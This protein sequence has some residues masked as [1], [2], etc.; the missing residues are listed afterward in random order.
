LYPDHKIF[1]Q[2]ALSQLID[3]PEDHPERQSIR[4]R[5]SQ[6]VADFVLCRSDLSVVAVIE[7]DDRSHESAVR[8]G[9]DARKTKALEDAGLRLVRIA[10]G[11][12][13]SGD[14][15]RGLVDPERTVRVR[16]DVPHLQPFAREETVLRLTETVDTYSVDAPLLRQ[17]GDAKAE[18]R[19]LKSLALKMVLGAVVFVGGWFIYSQVLPSAVRWAL[20]PLAVRQVPSSP[21]L[22]KA[23][24]TRAP[25]RISPLPVVAGPTAEELAERR[26]AQLQAAAALQKQKDLAW[27][28][29]YSAPTSCE[30]PVDW[31]AQVECGNQYIR[32]KREFEKQW[33]AQVGTQNGN[34]GLAQNTR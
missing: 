13:P 26:R 30:H 28:A 8:Q 5:F 17:P 31:N 19:A 24:L 29:F 33:S 12:L 16:L 32:A 18:S 7:L 34:A 23:P 11:S 25:A 10:A 4:N 2:V 22:T 27:A 15:L 9:A 1:V 14:N 3:V 21:T 6:L 20:Q